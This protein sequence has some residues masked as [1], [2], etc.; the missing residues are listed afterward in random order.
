MPYIQHHH[1]GAVIA[2]HH[3]GPIMGKALDVTWLPIEGGK[4]THMLAPL[5]F[6]YIAR[7]LFRRAGRQRAGTL[8]RI[9]QASSLNT[10]KEAGSAGQ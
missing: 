9:C 10:R 3:C 7:R 2:P 8:R 1:F 6:S 5:S 4:F